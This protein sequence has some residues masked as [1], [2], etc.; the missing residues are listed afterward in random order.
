MLQ[1][2]FGQNIFLNISSGTNVTAKVYTTLPGDVI[3]ELVLTGS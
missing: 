3:L 2:F 1:I